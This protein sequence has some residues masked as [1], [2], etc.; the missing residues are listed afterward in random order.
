MGNLSIDLR[1]LVQSTCSRHV[2]NLFKE[3]L[4][5]LQDLGD[6]HEEALDKLENALPQEYHQY[7]SLADHFTDEK[8]QRLR[9]EVLRRGNN[10]SRAIIDELEKYDIEFKNQ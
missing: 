1:Q 6:E 2:T 8:G 10:C 9:S 7:I 4:G 3:F 5:I